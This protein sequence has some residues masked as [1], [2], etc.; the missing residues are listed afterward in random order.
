MNP[1]SC[2]L[3]RRMAESDKVRIYALMTAVSLKGHD[4]GI[5]SII[6]DR[7]TEKTPSGEIRG[8]SRM[9]RDLRRAG[10]VSMDHNRPG[11]WRCN[12]RGRFQVRIWD[13]RTRE[14]RRIH[15]DTLELVNVAVLA[16]IREGH[17]SPIAMFRA[18][19]V[20]GVKRSAIEIG[21]GGAM[22]I[23]GIGRTHVRIAGNWEETTWLKFMEPLRP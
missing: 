19:W 9:L 17:A 10:Y 8:A 5:A 18:G 7:Q 4:C 2:K 11:E 20:Q 16:L 3:L 23:G 14:D 13:C 6:V 12:A 15:R 21:P 1:A 22:K